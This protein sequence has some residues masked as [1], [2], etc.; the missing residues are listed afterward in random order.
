MVYVGR[1]EGNSGVMMTS[2]NRPA[3]I[4]EVRKCNCKPTTINEYPS[5]IE[6]YIFCSISDIGIAYQE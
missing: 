3:S 2:K 6:A 5:V 1:R 4:V